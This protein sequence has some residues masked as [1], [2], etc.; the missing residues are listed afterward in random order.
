MS[1][2]YICRQFLFMWPHAKPAVYLI[3]FRCSFYIDSKYLFKSV[4]YLL[5][6]VWIGNVFFIW[7]LS[8][9]WR[10]LY[11]SL[12]L[13]S[14]GLIAFYWSLISREFIARRKKMDVLL[15]KCYSSIVLKRFFLEWSFHLQT[16]PCSIQLW[17]PLYS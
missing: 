2:L 4:D 1:W 3:N 9:F 14:I 10:C 15:L 7:V 8:V 17:R 5:F 13:T 11:N 12:L 16:Q 6:Q